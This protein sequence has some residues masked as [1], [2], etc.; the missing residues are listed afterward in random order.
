MD[1]IG[2]VGDGQAVNGV[3]PGRPSG[4]CGR[5]ASAGVE[6]GFGREDV[7][8]CRGLAA[9]GPTLNLLTAR[10]ASARQAALT[11]RTIRTNTDRSVLARH[12]GSPVHP[13]SRAQRGWGTGQR[14]AS[15]AIFSSSDLLAVWS[16]VRFAVTS[17]ACQGRV[18]SGELYKAGQDH[19]VL[20]L[21]S[22]CSSIVAARD[23]ASPFII[24]PSAR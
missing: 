1:G 3:G 11:D 5:A 10:V 24:R 9:G 4:P 23:A 19:K 16:G 21:E 12:D 6:G 14:I 20:R 17:D 8:H 13:L 2:A 18:G 22:N 7:R 15:T